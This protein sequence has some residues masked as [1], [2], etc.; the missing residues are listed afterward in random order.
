MKLPCLFA[1]TR[2]DVQLVHDMMTRYSF[3][4]H[5]QPVETPVS[6]PSIAELESDMR[7]MLDWARDFKK[8]SEVEQSKSKGKVFSSVR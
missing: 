7:K 5:S 6:L 3:F 1:I 4:E 2:D 8:R